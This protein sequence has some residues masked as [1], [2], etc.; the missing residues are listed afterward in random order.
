MGE[1]GAREG[2]ATKWRRGLQPCSFH[3]F[4]A[5]PRQLWGAQPAPIVAV[6]RSR[7]MVAHRDR[8]LGFVHV[9][10]GRACLFSCPGARRQSCPSGD[11]CEAC[12]MTLATYG[13]RLQHMHVCCAVSVGLQ[14]TCAF[15]P[16]P[17]PVN[18]SS[19]PWRL[20]AETLRRGLSRCCVEHK[21][22][23]LPFSCQVQQHPHFTAHH[24][25]PKFTAHIATTTH[26]STHTHHH[27]HH[28][29]R[30]H[31]SP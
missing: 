14:H 10:C 28:H 2:D 11:K 20:I 18:Q 27:H 1:M 6:L 7:T 17:A 21:K 8:T 31:Q 25:Y 30:R 19:R 12:I 13:R 4:S 26:L 23:T 16:S 15:T 3:F 29:H 5:R 22:A 9:A 24:Q